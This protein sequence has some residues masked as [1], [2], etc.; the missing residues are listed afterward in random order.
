MSF[1]TTVIPH[2]TV[3]LHDEPH[4]GADVRVHYDSHPT[5]GGCGLS[6]T[7]ITLYLGD[8]IESTDGTPLFT[9]AREDFEFVNGPGWT[10]RGY[11]SIKGLY[12]EDARRIL[13]LGI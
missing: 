11:D 10:F 7:Y 2:T 6:V 12:L 1:P 4:S 13:P 9:V 3:E 5:S 8:A